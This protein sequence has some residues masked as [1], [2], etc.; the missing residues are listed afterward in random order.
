MIIN[1]INIPDEVLADLL[2]GK[3]PAGTIGFDPTICEIDF[4]PFKKNAKRRRPAK[5]LAKLPWGWAK[6]SKANQKHLTS[7]SKHLPLEEKLEILDHDNELAKRT[8]IERELEL[9]EFC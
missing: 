9:I 3:R 5:M 1:S 2:K 7:F 6:E 8:L 4:K